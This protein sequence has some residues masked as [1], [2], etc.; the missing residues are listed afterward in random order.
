MTRTS[1]TTAEISLATILVYTWQYRLSYKLLL[2]QFDM[3]QNYILD[4]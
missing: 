4:M 3:Q 1:E 2:A